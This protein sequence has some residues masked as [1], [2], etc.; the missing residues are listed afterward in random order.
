MLSAILTLDDGTQEEV[1][2]DESWL[3]R[4]EALVA[5]I[6]EDNLVKAI[7]FSSKKTYIE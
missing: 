2:T 7:S 5:K 1:H 6:G 3:S 4:T